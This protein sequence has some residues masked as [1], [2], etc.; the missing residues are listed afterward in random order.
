MQRKLAPATD[1]CLK[2]PAARLV[3]CLLILG[4]TVAG[5]ATP[6][7]LASDAWLRATPGTDVAAVYLTLRNSGTEPVTVI[8]VRSPQA[9]AAMIHESQLTGTQS[10]MRP[11]ATLSIAPGET[12]RF[13]PGGLHVMLHMLSRPLSAGEELPLVLLLQGGGTLTVTAHVRAL[14]E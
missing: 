12:V 11:R 1:A 14:Q 10:A 5:A 13:E 2:S 4:L 8:G 7:L 6:A 3:A 9:Q